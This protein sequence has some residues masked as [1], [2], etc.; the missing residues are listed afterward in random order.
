MAST[1]FRLSNTHMLVG[2]T[3]PSGAITSGVA[4]Y[5]TNSDGNY[6]N[7]S[8]VFNT[9]GIPVA[10]TDVAA[11]L[12]IN[13]VGIFEKEIW[14]VQ[15]AE[16]LKWFRGSGLTNSTWQT[17]ATF[18]GAIPAD[19]NFLGIYPWFDNFENKRYYVT[20]YQIGSS[21]NWVGVRYDPDNDVWTSGSP[22]S[23]VNFGSS[24]AGVRQV[25]RHGDN[26]YFTGGSSL[27]AVVYV[28]NASTLSFRAISSN[29]INRHPV[30]L[31]V[32]N[33]KVYALYST[34]T[35]EIFVGEVRSSIV[36][37]IQL[38]YKGSDALTTSSFG[39]IESRCLLFAD[40][41][42]Q[43][44]SLASGS[45]GPSLYAFYHVDDPINQDGW[46]IWRLQED[47]PGSLIEVETLGAELLPGAYGAGNGVTKAGNPSATFKLLKD[48]P[49]YFSFSPAQDRILIRVN[50][51]HYSARGEYVFQPDYFKDFALNWPLV[52]TD[53]TP[54][55]KYAI[56]EDKDGGGAGYAPATFVPG[57]T[58][59]DNALQED[60]DIVYVSG[61]LIDSATW[62]IYYRLFPSPAIPAGSQVFV[63]WYFD[64]SGHAPTDRCKI[65]SATG[66]SAVVQSGNNILVT[67]LSGIDYTA[68]WDIG[69]SGLTPQDKVNLAPLVF[70]SGTIP[71]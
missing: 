16:V 43:N 15:S 21:V 61:E 41:A 20:A 57:T 38:Q 66:G 8:N 6:G 37:I 36:P 11:K 50:N 46:E 70:V 14:L 68:D 18:S 62:R 52:I 40:N 19:S 49:G 22:K 13:R 4:V 67:M 25:V 63:R 23:L 1:D 71:L 3:P 55:P 58:G 10:E 42:P 59:P 39:N 35:Q 24:N 7:P 47:S 44:L 65:N 48:N 28:F 27:D 54:A 26:F 29:T 34:N 51:A 60:F 5:R 9:A 69:A 30:D 45:F 17:Q 12:A 64:P 32:Y 33:D 53:G 2:A 56:R 31:A